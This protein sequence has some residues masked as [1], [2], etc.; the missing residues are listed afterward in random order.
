MQKQ[1]EPTRIVQEVSGHAG[2]LSSPLIP[3]ILKA[4]TRSSRPVVP[5]RSKSIPLNDSFDED[6]PAYVGP[7]TCPTRPRVSGVDEDERTWPV[8]VNVRSERSD[9]M[10]ICV[11]IWAEEKRRERCGRV[12]VMADL[13]ASWGQTGV[14]GAFRG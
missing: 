12:I 2:G 13:R 10:R 11:R 9:G 8:Y 1:D 4:L 3:E 7:S 14:A 6:D 5:S